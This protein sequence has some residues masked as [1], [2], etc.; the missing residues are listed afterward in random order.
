MGEKTVV[1][2]RSPPQGGRKE[3]QKKWRKTKKKRGV[4]LQREHRSTKRLRDGD[5][6]RGA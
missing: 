3:K 5:K 6:E 1:I 4:T 2:S